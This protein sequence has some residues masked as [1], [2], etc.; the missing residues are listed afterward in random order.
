MVH[1]NNAMTR[2]EEEKYANDQKN[3]KMKNYINPSP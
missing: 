2:V 3:T 1:D